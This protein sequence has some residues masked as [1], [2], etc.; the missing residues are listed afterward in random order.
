MYNIYAYYY[1]DTWRDTVVRIINKG[2]I[3]KKNK[4]QKEINT[5]R[6]SK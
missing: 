3:Y 4:R 2:G 6:M 1:N 5:R